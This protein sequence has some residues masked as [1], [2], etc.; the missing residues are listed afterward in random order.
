MELFLSIFVFAIALAILVKGADFLIDGAVALARHVG[1]SDFIIGLLLVAF[2]TSFPELVVS[3]ISSVKGQ[4]EIAIGNVIGSNIANIFVGLGLASLFIPLSA[5]REFVR[6]E[7][8]VNFLVT[9]LLFFSMNR[10]NS[11]FHLLPT[12]TRSDGAIFLLIFTFY[13][14][15][16]T[17]MERIERAELEFENIIPLPKALLFVVL[18]VSGVGIGGHFSVEKAVEI[19]NHLGISK[20]FMGLFSIAVGTS[21]PEFVTSVVSAR[22]GN[23]DIVLGNIAGSNIFNICMV[24]GVSSLVHPIKI[25]K[26][27]NIHIAFLLLAT[28][29]LL[30]SMFVGTKRTVDRKEGIL[31][32]LLYITYIVVAFRIE[33]I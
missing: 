22:K 23:A 30:L 28:S 32:L 12:L 27:A 5:T 2:G 6:R 14:Y 19:A 13:L 24:L 25:P 9:L 3:V 31:F 16:I 15:L 8:P 17:L 26:T 7:I 18:G 10:I 33:K 11:T 20:T 1:V 21:L 4:G 29:L